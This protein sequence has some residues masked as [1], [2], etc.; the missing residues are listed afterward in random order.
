VLF[1]INNKV[2]IVFFLLILVGFGSV[3]CAQSEEAKSEQSRQYQR[4][5][6]ELRLQGNLEEAITEQLKAVEI[7]PNDLQAQSVLGSLY[8][9]TA[10]EKNKPEYLQKAKEPL[11]KA[12][13]INPNDAVAHNM[14]ADALDQTGDKQGALREL[15]ESVRLDPKN[16]RY[17]NSLG[18]VYG[19][20]G[21]T[22]KEREFYEKAIVADDSY[23]A[24]FYN[25][26]LLEKAEGNFD[27]A[28]GFF[29]RSIKLADGNKESINRANEKIQEIEAQRKQTK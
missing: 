18:A 27:I 5:S 28:I 29:N 25:L 13:K 6:N 3:S 2:K 24:A 22:K 1:G 15:Q 16:A 21:D 12:I 20:L 7:T 26:A 10:Q 17:L 9:Q 11:E 8:I 14:L 4:K 23:S 19:L